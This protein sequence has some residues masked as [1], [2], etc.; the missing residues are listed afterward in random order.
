MRNESE[1]IEAQKESVRVGKT[2][3]DQ[4]TRRL[5][6]DGPDARLDER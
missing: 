1:D 5:Q 6:V 2:G 4:D 3:R